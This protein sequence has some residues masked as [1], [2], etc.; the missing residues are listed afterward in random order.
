MDIFTS[1]NMEIDPEFE[2]ECPKWIDLKDE[3]QEMDAESFS[4]G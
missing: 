4:S 2:F 1:Y 3:Q